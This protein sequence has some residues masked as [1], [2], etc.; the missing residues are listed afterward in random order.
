[1]C[2]KKNI[3]N[4]LTFLLRLLLR[5]VLGTDAEVFGV[6]SRVDTDSLALRI[7]LD[8]AKLEFNSALRGIGAKV[9]ADV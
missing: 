3:K 5:L 4:I 7:L 9:L 2:Q 6:S 1:L 8:V